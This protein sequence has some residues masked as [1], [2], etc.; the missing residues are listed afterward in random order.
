MLWLPPCR[1]GAALEALDK[2]Q[3]RNNLQAND[4]YLCAMLAAAEGSLVLPEQQQQR[5]ATAATAHQDPHTPHGA[6]SHAGKR[7]ACAF[8]PPPY[9]SCRCLLP[10]IGHFHLHVLGQTCTL[11]SHTL[12]S[13]SYCPL[14]T[15]TARKQ[16]L[17]VLFYVCSSLGGVGG[18]GGMFTPSYAP[19]SNIVDKLQSLSASLDSSIEQL[20]KLLDLLPAQLDQHKAT[21][22]RL[23][24]T[25]FPPGQVV[26]HGAGGS[27]SIAGSV[28]GPG[29]TAGSTWGAGS[30][31][32]AASVRSM[33]SAGSG[34]TSSA[35]GGTQHL[36]PQL[37]LPEVAEATAALKACLEQL[38]AD[39]NRA[40]LKQNETVKTMTRSKE[41]QLE[42]R[43]MGLFFTAP[44]ELSAEVDNVKAQVQ[45]MQLDQALSFEDESS[46]KQ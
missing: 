37:T 9:P 1:C 3:G 5:Q 35:A 44:E 43:V 20:H 24:R 13:R 23:H 31:S 46:Y 10:S 18:D 45:R 27:S 17:W 11:L 16:L 21:A 41:K 40:V 30:Q 36:Q 33:H 7:C 22:C 12:S 42:R 25:A 14:H 2:A 6:L 32:A 34:T 8:K 15:N 29:S 28:A 39:T 19:T 4:S 26:V 38:T